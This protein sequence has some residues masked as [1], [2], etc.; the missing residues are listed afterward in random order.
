MSALLDG[1]LRWK[2]PE[3]CMGS[4][5]QAGVLG[6]IRKQT[7]EAIERKPVSRVPP[8][9]LPQF[10]P[11]DSCL[12]FLPSLPF[13]VDHDGGGGLSHRTKSFPP[14]VTLGHKV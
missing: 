3:H 4:Y 7:A 2:A 6:C 1:Q 5:P 14:Q 12:E 13:V 11:P 8:R 9:L 10:L